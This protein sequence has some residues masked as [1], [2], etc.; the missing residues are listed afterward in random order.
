MIRVA[1]VNET[2][3]VLMPQELPTA[4]ELRAAASQATALSRECERLAKLKEPKAAAAGM[5]YLT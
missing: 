5:P 3:K 4:A 1:I 2:G